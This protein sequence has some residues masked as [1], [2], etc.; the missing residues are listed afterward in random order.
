DITAIDYLLAEEGHD[1]NTVFGDFAARITVWDF[2]DGTGPYFA[3]SEQRSQDRMKNAKPNAESFDNKFT[4]VLSSNG[5][6]GQMASIPARLS[7]GAWAFNAY[8]LTG[9]SAGSYRT[10]VKGFSSNPANTK[11]QARIITGVPGDYDYFDLPIN[12]NAAFGSEEASIEVTTRAG[13][14]LYLIVA[15]TPDGYMG[16]DYHYNYEYSIE[17]VDPAKANM[18]SDMENTKNNEVDELQEEISVYPTNTDGH[19]II[20][21][22]NENPELKRLIVYNAVGKTIPFNRIN[23]GHITEV[24][25][26]GPSGIYYVGVEGKNINRVF[27]VIKTSE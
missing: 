10:R 21:M 14:E 5:T 3:D 16:F 7:P 2:E 15:T 25:F 22:N 20:E 17:A 19:L 9:T 27:K 24:N 12:S 11:F 8:K 18:Y 4:D 13:E 23:N 26:D 6:N 1:L